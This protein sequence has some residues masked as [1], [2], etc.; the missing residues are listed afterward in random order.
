ML[1]NA[2]LFIGCGKA[3]ERPTAAILERDADQVQP[4]Q[5]ERPEGPPARYALDFDSKF[6]FT[7][8]K[9]GGSQSGSI[10]IFDGWVEMYG[11]DPVYM[12]AE[13]DLVM[14]SLLTDDDSLTQILKSDKFFNTAVYPEGRFVLMRVDRTG[15]E[16][17]LTGELTLKGVGKV[18]SFPAQIEWDENTLRIQAAF[19]AD[20]QWWNL[21]YRGLGEHIM[22]DR[23]DIEID[24][25][26]ERE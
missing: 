26:G 12:E 2:L 1:L 21:T 4:A 19:Q 11:D 25:L 15:D 20:R 5:R 22:R 16:Y 17:Q 6:N 10:L 13:I 7:G 18:L 23:V 8:Y 9:V 14:D 3:P 24:I